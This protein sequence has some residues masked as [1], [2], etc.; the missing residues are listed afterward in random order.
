MDNL[1][2]T[3]VGAALGEAGLHG[4][5]PLGVAA[6]VIAANIPDVHGVLY[7]L[8]RPVAELGFRRCR[9]CR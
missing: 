1:R 9:S 5:T 7:W 8:H 6:R 4:K 2:H 3:L